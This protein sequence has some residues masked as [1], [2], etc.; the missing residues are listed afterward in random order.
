M[1]VTTLLIHSTNFVLRHGVTLKHD[2]PIIMDVTNGPQT[3]Q[4]T[5]KKEP[6]NACGVGCL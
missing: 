4:K 5:K 6:V 1:R 2:V 3:K